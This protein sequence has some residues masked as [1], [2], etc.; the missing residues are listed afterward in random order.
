MMVDFDG[1]NKSIWKGV[2]PLKVKI[3]T[4]L[5]LDNKIL[6][7]YGQPSKMWTNFLIGH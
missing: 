1:P 5:S 6:I 7:N 2:C 4:Y 3:F